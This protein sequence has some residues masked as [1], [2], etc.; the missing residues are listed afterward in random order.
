MCFCCTVWVW[1]ICGMILA[2]ENWSSETQMCP[3][4]T[5]AIKIL[6]LP[7]ELGAVTSP[8]WVWG[9]NGWGGGGAYGMRCTVLLC[10]F[11]RWEGPTIAAPWLPSP[12]R[13]ILST[14]TCVLCMLSVHVEFYPYFLWHICFGA[15]LAATFVYI[16]WKFCWKILFNASC[17]NVNWT[18][19]LVVLNKNIWEQILGNAVWF[20]CVN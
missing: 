9:R 18:S 15:W 3:S 13:S 4:A 17:G 19:L 6:T 14:H 8:L 11:C 1:S 7:T 5:L 2:G 20:V 16:E 10:V 12:F